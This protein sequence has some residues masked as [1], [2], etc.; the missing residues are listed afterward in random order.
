MK[1]LMMLSALALLAC[2]CV[3]AQKALAVKAEDTSSTYTV[4]LE[5]TDSTLGDNPVC[6]PYSNAVTLTNYYMIGNF[7]GVASWSYDGSKSLRMIANG[8][9]KGMLQ[10]IKLTEGDLF[11]FVE[12]TQ[13]P[14]WE[15]G[16]THIKSASTD[17]FEA[18]GKYNNIK[19][20]KTGWYDFYLNSNSELWISVST[21]TATAFDWDNVVTGI[22]QT[23]DDK[24]VTAFEI[25]ATKYSK[26]SSYLIFS[27]SSNLVNANN[28]FATND[29]SDTRSLA[30]SSSNAVSSS[31]NVY[32]TIT[33]HF[34]NGSDNEKVIIK[35]GDSIDSKDAKKASD[36]FYD[37]TLEGWYTDAGYNNKFTFGSAIATDLGLYAKWTYTS[38]AAL[39][40]IEKYETK[41]SLSYT[42]SPTESADSENSTVTSSYDI[43][44]VALRFGGVVAKDDYEYF[45]DEITVFGIFLATDIKEYGTL[46]AAID[47]GKLS[48]CKYQ[49]LYYKTIKTDAENGK[50]PYFDETNYIFN[51]YISV[52]E[53]NYDKTVYAIAYLKYGNNGPTITYFGEK[54]FSVKSI[55]NE[56][57]TK[58]TGLT[59]EQVK[60]TNLMGSLKQLAGITE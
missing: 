35:S 28:G 7:S 16:F 39:A 5:D 9:D 45:N 6:Y 54:S 26:A 40:N 8:G 23:I 1:K 10:H 56:Y 20:K 42:Y 52:S 15:Y 22:T 58:H 36:K 32:N 51:A 44:N 11:R 25:D 34:N 37:Y 38:T 46:K 43:S 48:E 14:V 55:A 49:E 31:S 4:F 50:T 29:L 47:A 3:N 17:Y 60:D 53:E 30:F 2:P 59:D 57:Y 41:A 12:P 24:K 13:T 27:S 18:E 19:V 33:Y 21:E